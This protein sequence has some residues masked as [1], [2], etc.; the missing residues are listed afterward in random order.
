[1]KYLHVNG[2]IIEGLSYSGKTSVF[3]A[4]KKLHGD[5][6]ERT[7][8]AISENY[9]QI[10][11]KKNDGL[12]S[13]NEKEHLQLLKTRV[14]SIKRIGDWGD[15]LGPASQAS[16]GVFILFERFHLNHIN[17][18]PKSDIS[19]LELDLQKC[20]LKT[21]LLTISPEKVYDR[22]LLRY[23][24]NTELAKQK[25]NAY[26]VQQKNYISISQKSKIETEIIVT[27]NMDWNKIAKV[28][29][30]FVDHSCKP[31]NT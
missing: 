24:G 2:I 20:N 22:L 26:L 30:D 27:D 6:F 13:L 5:K 31:N 4:I 7:L 8:I 15:Q 19:D 14:E 16:R 12:F 29:L 3:N 18:F 17:T 1:M 23:N 9:S 11:Y 25:V 21:I 28:A 10:L